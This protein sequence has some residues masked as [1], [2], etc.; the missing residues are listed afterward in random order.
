MKNTLTLKNFFLFLFFSIAA[1]SCKKGGSD[2]GTTVKP[3]TLTG[4]TWTSN[5]VEFQKADGSWEAQTDGDFHFAFVFNSDNTFS[6]TQTYFNGGKGTKTG[7][8]HLINNDTQ[9]T[10]SGNS[11]ADTYTVTQLTSSTLQWTAIPSS[12]FGKSG[13]RETFSH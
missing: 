4:V 5:K 8:W 9:V 12:F 6:V 7:T 11:Y 3:S 10:L 1:A 13:V 2:N